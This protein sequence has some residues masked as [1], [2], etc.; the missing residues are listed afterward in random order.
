MTAL[1]M[2]Y[3]FEPRDPS[4]RVTGLVI[5]VALHAVLGYALISGM[6]RKGLNL[7]K[8]P[9]EAVVIQEVILPPPP[10][11]QPKAIKT[12]EP[13]ISRAA[14]PP[15][16]QH[17]VAQPL[18]INPVQQTQPDT[19]PPAKLTA[20]TVADPTPTPTPTLM[21]ERHNTPIASMESEYA[22]QIRAM[23]NSAKRYPTGRAASQQRPQGRVKVWFTLAR[24]GALLDAG[25]LESSNSNLL[26]DAAIA[27]VR[28][29]VFPP[30]PAN[31][32]VD[33]AYHQFSADM[34]FS[35]PS[36]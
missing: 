7:I 23:L 9:L 20:V 21:V 11:P 31:T 2:A 16:L 13:L 29:S 5:V 27:T 14:T 22:S 4:G 32:W 19:T 24:G 33:Q 1:S 30:F 17:D 12:P 15:P 34:A 8:K 36:A 3:R 35:P 10:P 6:A 26:D 25:I 18:E 28:R